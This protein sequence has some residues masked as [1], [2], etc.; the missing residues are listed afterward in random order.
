MYPTIASSPHV[1]FSMTKCSE[2]PYLYTR[3]VHCLP[4]RIVNKILPQAIR[5]HLRRVSYGSA[6]VGIGCYRWVSVGIVRYWTVLGGDG[7]VLYLIPSP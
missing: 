2:V 3:T 5:C 7:A 4:R 6:L 1:D